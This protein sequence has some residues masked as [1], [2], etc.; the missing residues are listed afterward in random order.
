M[1][2]MPALDI[3]FER[4][5]RGQSYSYLVKSPSYESLKTGV[6]AMEKRLSNHEMF[7]DVS[8]KLDKELRE[9]SVSILR[10]KTASLGIDVAQIQ[11]TLRTAFSGQEVSRILTP[12][13][14]YPVKLT[15]LPEYRDTPEALSKIYLRSPKTSQLIPLSALTHVDEVMAPNTIRHFNQNPSAH[16]QFNL[17]EGISLDQAITELERI[18][19]EVF[20][21]NV[22]ATTSGTT[23][24][25][26]AYSKQFRAL[27]VMAIFVMYLILGILYESFIDPLTILSSLP[28]AGLGAALTLLYFGQPLSLYGFIGLILLL[29][30]VK[31]NGIMIVD[32][33][34]EILK[35][36]E[37]DPKTAVYEACLIRFRP[38]MMTTFAA[39]FGAL[40]I[41]I[42]MGVAATGKETLGLVIVGG[43]T[44]SQVFTLIFTPVIFLSFQRLK[45]V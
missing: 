6:R 4:G 32:Q 15:L 8:A 7:S 2:A 41:A 22:S 11:D 37:T 29:G 1:H 16:I 44:F 19:Q 12:Q 10:D 30:I 3:P 35:T 24:E 17:K 40:P 34:K 28:I 26:E 27:I 38:I 42:G 20:P 31:K 5:A 23:R 9:V 39:V 25:F 13:A 18:G 14:Y 21:E 43:L 45:R 33:A 36:T